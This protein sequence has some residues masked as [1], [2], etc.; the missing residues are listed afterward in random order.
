[1]GKYWDRMRTKLKFSKNM[2]LYSFRDTGMTDMIKGGIDPLSVKQLADHHSLEMTTI[3]TN[4]VDP[5][6][7][8]IVYESSPTF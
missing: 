2:V 4:H 8:K 7:Q 5:N 1:M 3:Y 6:L